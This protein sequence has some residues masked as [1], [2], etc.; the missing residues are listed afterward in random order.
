M[1]TVTSKDGTAIA[2][3]RSGDGPPIVMVG[4][5]LSTRR[6]AET[7]AGLLAPSFTVYAYDRR[8]RGDSG[9]MP[10]YAVEREVEDIY[11]LVEDAGGS[12]VAFGH[13]SG[14]VLALEAAAHILGITKV[15]LYE[16]P[17]IVDASRAPLPDD[18]I[19]RLT[20]LA[21]TDRPGDAVEYFMITGPG[22][23]A[24]AVASMKDAPF[25]SALEA[26][27]HTLSYD[28]RIM[29]DQMAGTSLPSDR[30]ASVTIPTLVIDGGASP[31]WL[32]N[33]AQGL[34]DALPDARRRT[35]EGQTHDVDPVLL[36]P[37]LEEFFA[38]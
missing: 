14:G 6:A 2:F 8:G 23:P 20:E 4:G 38:G 7:L 24:E 15:A 12:A 5:A 17:F 18:Y 27:A 9:D 11:S 37:V 19:E 28:G 36:A 29:G 26:V 16:P 1:N 25:W 35:I 10:P 22:V 31:L 3:D 34:V 33:A 13:S 21:S 30:W 32:G